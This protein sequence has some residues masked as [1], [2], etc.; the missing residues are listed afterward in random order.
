MVRRRMLYTTETFYF[1]AAVVRQGCGGCGDGFVGESALW[2][3]GG[4]LLRA[5]I[6][7]LAGWGARFRGLPS[8]LSALFVSLMLS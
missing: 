3:I 7:L 8:Q 5:G 1:N 2:L 4:V 6:A